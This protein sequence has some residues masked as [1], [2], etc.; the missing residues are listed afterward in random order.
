LL[1]VGSIAEALLAWLILPT[2]NWRLLVMVSALP[3]LLL[4]VFYPALPESPRYLMVSSFSN[5]QALLILAW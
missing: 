2:Y 5:T 4:L 3:F 1:Q